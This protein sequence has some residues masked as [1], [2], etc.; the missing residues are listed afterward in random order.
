M[1]AIAIRGQVAEVIHE[2]TKPRETR[3]GFQ[4]NREYAFEKLEPPE[5]DV[6]GLR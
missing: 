1:I 4:V 3:R 5:A 2:L 6:D